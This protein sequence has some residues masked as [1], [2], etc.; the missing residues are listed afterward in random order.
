MKKNIIGMEP[1]DA[2][3]AMLPHINEHAKT[4]RIE[5]TDVHYIAQFDGL[6]CWGIVY[7]DERNG[8]IHEIE[9]S[10]ERDTKNIYIH[11]VR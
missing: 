3:S 8:G 5:L 9:L 6:D 1:K 10:Q 4:D 11:D 7:E 2:I